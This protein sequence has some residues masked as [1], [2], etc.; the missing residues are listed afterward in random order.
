MSSNIDDLLQRL[1]ARAA[2]PE[3]RTSARPSQFTASI[4]TLGPSDLVS[5]LGGLAADLDRVVASN[6]TDGVD[7][8]GRARAEALGDAMRTP[9]SGDL[10]AP[11]TP[12]EL[13]ASEAEFGGP[14]PTVLRRAYTEVAD[15][16]FGPGEGLLPLRQVRDVLAG[17]RTG[18][19][20]PR[21]RRWPADLVP[22][23]S[24]D[25]GFD[26]V[27]LST[28]RI[29][30]WDPE[31]LSERS[32]QARFARSFTVVAPSTE[33][34]LDAWVQSRTQQEML[35][36]RLRRSRVD[37]ARAARASIAAKTP[38]ERAAMGLPEVGWER[39]VWGGIGLDEEDGGSEA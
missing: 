39:I 33:A 7:L 32:S 5:M 20:L 38:E 31:G 26:G 30:A 1:R 10:P 22:L 36:E 13:T 4:R 9:A 35:E 24:T 34:W 25:P 27:E 14:L 2:D 21:G 29:V 28:G 11:A 37:Q 17:L 18:E 16:G 12:D 23:V 15:G 19:E 8:A 3:R 6:R